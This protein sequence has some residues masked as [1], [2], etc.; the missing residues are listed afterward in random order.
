MSQIQKAVELLKREDIRDIAIVMHNKPD[1]DSLGSGVALEECL[2][3]LGKEVDLIFHN[4][5]PNKFQ[6]IVGRDRVNRKILP[7]FGKIY[8]LLIMVDFSDPDR[9]FENVEELSDYIMVLDHHVDNE[10]YGDL[11]V[12]ENCSATGMIAYKIIEQL[13]QITPTIANA[14]YMAIVTDTNNFRNNNTNSNTHLMT[15]KLLSHGADIHLVNSIFD[16]K[17]L[18]YFHL[19]GYTFKDIK[20]DSNYKI[21]YLVVTRDKIK[22]SGATGEEVAQLIDQ[23]R[24]TKNSDIVFLFIEGIKNVRISARSRKTPVNDILK[25][26]GGGGHVNAA[27][28]AIDGGYIHYVVQDV[29]QY[30]KKYIEENRKK[31]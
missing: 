2:M 4:K 29:L 14:I 9:T 11:Y 27:G 31:R 26:F 22:S 10:P 7:S 6:P 12:W 19:M 3:S 28:C 30:T 16:D 5:V 24:W 21:S 23:I 17:T 18:G 15:A 20:H 8:D 1:G 13:S 25:H